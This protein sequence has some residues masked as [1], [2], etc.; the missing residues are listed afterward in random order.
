MI[1]GPGPPRRRAATAAEVKPADPGTEYGGDGDEDNEL[2]R[3][4]A[5]AVEYA[6]ATSIHGLKYIGE[7]HR[8]WCE[9]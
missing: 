2:K 7:P 1:G 4:G 3:L 6:D 9:R 8:H 5:Q